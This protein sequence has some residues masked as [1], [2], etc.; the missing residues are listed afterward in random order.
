VERRLKSLFARQIWRNEGFYEVAN[1]QDP[2]IRKALE[3]VSQ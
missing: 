2:V 3:V 1:A